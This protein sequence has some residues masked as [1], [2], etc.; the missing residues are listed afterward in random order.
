[1]KTLLDE[2]LPESLGKAPQRLRHQVDSVNRLRLKGL[3][4]AAEL[5]AEARCCG[6]RQIVNLQNEYKRRQAP[7]GPK[8][9][10][11]A[12][13]RDWRQPISKR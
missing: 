3:A 6:W 1:M 5:V 7:V 9:T 8:I 2:N 4:Y 10:K 13:G 12:F 11:R